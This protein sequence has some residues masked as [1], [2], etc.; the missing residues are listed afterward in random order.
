M[1]LT[2]VRYGDPVLRK[3]GAQIASVTPELQQLIAD[4]FETMK[5]SRG[6]GL[7]AQQIGH[8]L[9]LTVIDVRGVKDRPSKLWLAGQEADVE[10]FMP[11]VLLNPVVHPTG[12]RV[13]APE[14]C[15]SFPDIFGEVERTA[16]VEVAA[17]NERGERY[18]CWMAQASKPPALNE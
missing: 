13:A 15:L 12:P 1:I 14:G 5:V 11:L 17:Q 6:I 16:E 8:A 9:Q 3:K 18:S 2:V 7:A 10:S 4:M